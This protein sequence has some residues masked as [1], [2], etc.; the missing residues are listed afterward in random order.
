MNTV[1]AIGVPNSLVRRFQ[2]HPE[3]A[4]ELLSAARLARDSIAAL[5]PRDSSAVMGK[6][7]NELTRVIS[8]AESGMPFVCKR[9]GKPAAHN[10]CDECE[11]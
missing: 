9:C 10:M 4:L 1:P 5:Y 7:W 2:E 11:Q 3:Y 8:Q 6:A